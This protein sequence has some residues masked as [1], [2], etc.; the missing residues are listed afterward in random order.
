M[1]EFESSGYKTYALAHTRLNNYIKLSIAAV[2][3]LFKEKRSDKELSELINGLIKDSGERWTPRIFNDPEKELNALK[4]DLAKTGIIWAYSAFDVFFKQLE[5]MLS[6]HFKA[7]PKV[8]KLQQNTPE[9]DGPG[10]EEKKEAKII[11]L[12]AKLDWPLDNI[13]NLLPILKFYELLRHCV[14]HRSGYPSESLV[15]MSSSEEFKNAI[16]NWK[17]KFEHKNISPP[18]IISSEEIELKGHHAI[19]YSETC[20]RIARDINQKYSELIDVN[21]LVG[22]I[23]KR[24]LIEPKEL[25]PP[26]AADYSRYI[27]F[28]LQNQYNI[29]IRPY[30]KI[31]DYYNGDDQTKKEHHIRYSQLKLAS[32]KK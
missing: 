10:E 11:A 4:N 2:E 30:K 18:P 5:G 1:E 13:Q 8:E 27:A 6:S 31:Y 29:V 23:I 7:K 19:L 20:L 3:Y 15:K 21:F 26:F 25:Q 12:Y 28:H 14:A 16:A 17:T 24:Y 9:E 32:K 22:R